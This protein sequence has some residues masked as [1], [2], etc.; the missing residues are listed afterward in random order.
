MKIKLQEAK[1]IEAKIK[2]LENDLKEI[3]KLAD[4]KGMVISQHVCMGTLD[5]YKY[6]LTGV[7]IYPDDIEV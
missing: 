6:I 4:A 5:R 1:E 7:K 3:L 2:Q